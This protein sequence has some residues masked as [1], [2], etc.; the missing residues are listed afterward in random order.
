MLK[1]NLKLYNYNVFEEFDKGWPIL[2]CGDREN[3]VNSMT[4][5]WGGMGVLWGKKVAFIFVRHSRYTFDFI[6]KS[7]SVT[8]SFLTDDYKNEKAIFGSKSGRDIDK[9]LASGLHKTLDV[10]F[11]GYYITEAKYVLKMKKLYSIDIPYE[12]LPSEIRNQ[13][14]SNGDMH[15]MYVCEIMQY[16]ENEE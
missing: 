1:K 11:N 16:L 14:Y 4:I 8:L 15:R 12:N 13:Y 7:S 6:E 3:G 2:T 9:F 5:S 10:D